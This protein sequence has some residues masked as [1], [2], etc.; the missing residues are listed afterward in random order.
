MNRWAILAIL[1]IARASLGFQFQ[2]VGSVSE[3]MAADLGLTY[4]QV[5]TLIGLFMLPG[6]ILSLPTGYLGGF[7][8]D[9]ALVCFG[10]ACLAVGGVLVAVS[11][12][13]AL[14]A[15]GRLIC[16]AGFVFGTVFF[17]K[18][19]T[20]WF[21][22]KEIATAMG[23]LVMSWPFGIA[24][25]QIGH[26]WLAKSF[27][28]QMAFYAASAFCVAGF[29]LVFLFYRQPANLQSTK[30]SAGSKLN[31]RE[32]LLVSLA[33]IVW[34]AFNAAYIVYLSFAPHLLMQSGFGPIHAAAT[35]SLAS[36]AM[37]VSIPACGQLADRSGLPDHVI[38]TCLCGGVVALLLL[39]Y[40]VAS[41]ALCLAVGL[42]GMA[43]AG[44]IMILPGEVLRPENRA[45]GIGIFF[46]WYFVIT[47]PAPMIAGWLYDMSGKASWPLYFAAVLFVATATANLIFRLVQ[48]RAPVR[49]A[50]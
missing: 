47:A 16:G 43:P 21:S 45:F 42:I 9:R 32:F 50:I 48:S 23:V 31:R 33:A 49:S 46:S 41:F 20:D 30:S 40:D 38:Y 1:F 17:A 24:I 12:N 10:L 37:I 35:A 18:M 2:T 39:P 26:G 19:I 44:V 28:W 3:L 5:G 13:F 8:G 34:A 4:T 29:S 14:A 25:G 22:G 27:S 6:L 11:Q 7:A 36:W 15:L